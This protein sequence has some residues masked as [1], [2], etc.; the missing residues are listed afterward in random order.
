MSSDINYKELSEPEIDPL[1]D[2]L[3]ILQNK[4]RKKR[5]RGKNSKKGL[6]KLFISQNDPIWDLLKP[7]MQEKSAK[8]SDVAMSTVEENKFKHNK[9]RIGY[10]A[11][12]E[13]N[14]NLSKKLI[15][16]LQKGNSVKTSLTYRDNGETSEGSSGQPARSR[17]NSSNSDTSTNLHHNHLERMRR[18]EIKNA[19]LA[20]KA[21]I[22]EIR[23][24]DRI[25]KVQILQ[26]AVET[27]S[28]ITQK[29]N[30]KETMLN[31]QMKRKEL[32]EVKL[33]RL[34]ETLDPLGEYQLDVESNDEITID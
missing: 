8:H 18:A 2:P 31:L 14:F 28:Y 26:K 32:L 17:K 22:P 33:A 15:K 34:R 16:N 30:I 27:I 10:A 23:N 29:V 4:K 13:T 5:K 20:L 21:T 9:K 25:P 11:R 19:V 6:L 7:I 24:N 3:E 12:D 1:G